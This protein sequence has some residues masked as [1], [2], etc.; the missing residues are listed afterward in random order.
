MRIDLHQHIWTEPPLDVL[1]RRERLPL[2]R[3]EHGLTILHSAGEQPYV[4]DVASES[5]GRRIKLVPADDLDL[6]V[7]AL[8][9]PIGST[10]QTGRS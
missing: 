10:S 8:S 2:I 1:E 7:V 5:P 9:S 6:A 4:I 3:R